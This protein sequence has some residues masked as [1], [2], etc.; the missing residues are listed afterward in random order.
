MENAGQL[1]RATL[2]VLVLCTAIFLIGFS[3]NFWTKSQFEPGL[4]FH[5][6]IWRICGGTEFQTECYDIDLALL[7]EISEYIHGFSARTRKCNLFDVNLRDNSR[8]ACDK[9]CE[10]KSFKHYQERLYL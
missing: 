5:S 7:H 2:I 10:L 1:K 9:K 8:S 6:G 4:I 3:T